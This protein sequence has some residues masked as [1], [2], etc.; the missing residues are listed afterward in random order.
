MLVNFRGPEETLA[1]EK[2]RFSVGYRVL[3]PQPIK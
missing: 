1:T 3:Q 2:S